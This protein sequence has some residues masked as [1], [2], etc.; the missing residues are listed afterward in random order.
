M[1]PRETRFLRVVRRF[2]SAA[3]ALATLALVGGVQAGDDAA[4]PRTSPAAPTTLEEG[5]PAGPV[6]R[7]DLL[8]ADFDDST[9]PPAGWTYAPSAP[10]PHRWA[11]TTESWNVYSGDGAAVIRWTDTASPDEWLLTPPLDLTGAPS[12]TTLSF[13]YRTDPFWFTQ[14]S[15]AFAANVSTNGGGTWAAL[16]SIHDVAETGWAWRN[17]VVDLAGYLDQS[18]VI[19]RFRYW[20]NSAADVAL[21]EI[22]VGTP[23]V[24][25]PAND[26]CAGALAGGFRFGPAVAT[27]VVNGDTRFAT[28]DYSLGA[29]DCTG[30]VQTGRDVVWMVEVPAAHR[31]SAV[32]DP[33]GDWLGTLFLIEDC[34][35]AA[36][37]C[38]AGDRGF[39]GTARVE[40]ANETAA[41]RE[42]RLVVTGDGSDAGE[43]AL[44]ATI[45]PGV[46][47]EALGF[48]VLKSMH[49][50]APR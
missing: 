22:R 45:E 33:S 24:A 18:A 28:H 10:A 47:V 23:D 11:R 43:F 1:I 41:T 50:G 19:L 36:A 25:A 14:G 17:V 31:F 39:S 38:V 6:I 34:A 48:G 12:G 49:R 46:G 42:Y 40:I 7:G 32:L 27:V 21:D 8:A 20:G 44:T 13:W 37:T 5:S 2:T 15:N 9:F 30:A 35:N 16:F 29:S 3:M 4:S 26:D